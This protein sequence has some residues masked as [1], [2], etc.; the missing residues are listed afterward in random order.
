MKQR[1]LSGDVILI[2]VRDRKQRGRR[3]GIRR[4]RH[5]GQFAPNPKGKKENHT[6]EKDIRNFQ[7]LLAT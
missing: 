1:F 7:P 6:F 2:Y 5:I 3:K 4:D